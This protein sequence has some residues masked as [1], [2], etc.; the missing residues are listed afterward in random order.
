MAI[1]KKRRAVLWVKILKTVPRPDDSHVGGWQAAL[2]HQ[3][4]IGNLTETMKRTYE[5]GF[6][7]FLD[8]LDHQNTEWV[9]EELIRTWISGLHRQGHNSFSIGFWLNCVHSFFAWAVSEGVWDYDPTHRVSFSTNQS[10]EDS[11]V[12]RVPLVFEDVLSDTGQRT[13]RNT[14]ELTG[15]Y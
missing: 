11:G 10:A 3:V 7:Q 4:E 14:E 15:D 12:G 2:G 13:Q 5:W 9:S 6:A 8:W 1:M